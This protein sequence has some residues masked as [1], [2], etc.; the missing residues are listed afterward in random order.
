MTSQ[1]FPK[2]PFLE[3]L[4]EIGIALPAVLKAGQ[5]I[6]KIYQTDFSVTMKGEND[7]LTQADLKSNQLLKKALSKTGHSILSE[8]DADSQERLSHKK[9]WIIDPLDGTKEF[10]DKNGEFSI[11]VGLVEDNLPVLGIIY[12]PTTGL[13]YLTQKGQ[14]AYEKTL[15]GWKKL[16]V[17]DIFSLSSSRAVVSRSH[18]S[19]SDRSFLQLLQVAS[20]LQKGSAGIKA[21]E[22]CRGQAE[23]YF[24]PSNKLKQWDTCAPYCLL[25]EAGGKATDLK[26][27]DLRYNIK[28]VIHED[29]VLFSN[30]KIHHLVVDSYKKF[31]E[32]KSI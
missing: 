15:N 30:G 5:A 22:I 19:D 3:P 31:L 18:L 25:A 26:G 8:E 27:N 1:K 10:V 13:L 9:I 21:G 4:P 2:L 11:I 6:L 14:G 23:F 20:F 29:G 28:D 32:K 17:S 24:N 12:Q 16:K 7:P